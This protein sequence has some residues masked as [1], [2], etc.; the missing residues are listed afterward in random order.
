MK[1]K[2]EYSSEN[3]KCEHQNIEQDGGYLV[4]KDCGLILDERIDF[5]T[6]SSNK[7]Y[8]DSQIDYERRI[9]L[10][11]SKATQDPHGSGAGYWLADPAQR[12]P[13]TSREHRYTETSIDK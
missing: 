9:R 5:E 3:S 7:I 2:R 4:C 11:D 1:K 6:P 13:D 8:S 10:E 12:L